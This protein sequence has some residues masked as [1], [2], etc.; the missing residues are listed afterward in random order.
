MILYK[1]FYH[2]IIFTVSAFI[3][4]YVFDYFGLPA[5]AQNNLLYLFIL[6]MGYT[7]IFFIALLLLSLFEGD[8][9]E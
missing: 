8:K 9:S 1:K 5:L 4:F 2:A 7:I 3:G 6:F